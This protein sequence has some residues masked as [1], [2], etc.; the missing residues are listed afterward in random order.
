MAHLGRLAREA[1]GV[2]VGDPDQPLRLVKGQRAQEQGVD[3][4]EYGGAGADTEPDDE[5]GEG[6]E[7]GVPAQRSKGVA[8][9]LQNAVERGQ[10]AGVGHGRLLIYILPIGDLVTEEGKHSTARVS[11]GEEHDLRAMALAQFRIAGV[12]DGVGCFSQGDVDGIVGGKVVPQFPNPAHQ[13]RVRIAFRAECRKPRQNLLAPMRIDT[14]A[15]N[16][17]PESAHHFHVE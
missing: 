3:D 2:V 14:P 6:G 16:Q 10:T 1:A 17:A 7:C 4:A 12:Q 13:G 9:I 11:G 5:D 15:G 8:Q